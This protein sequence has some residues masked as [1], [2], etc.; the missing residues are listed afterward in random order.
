MA[1]AVSECCT[2]WAGST[3]FPLLLLAAVG[4]Y[5]VD[6]GQGSSP[7]PCSPY[8]MWCVALACFVIALIFAL[9]APLSFAPLKFMYAGIY[10]AFWF[11]LKV[12]AYIYLFMWLR[13]TLPRFRFDQLMRLGW[14][15]LIP[16]ALVNVAGV[17]VGLT[18]HSELGWNRWLAMAPTT[19]GTIG[20]ALLLIRWNDK[21]SAAA[22][23][24]LLGEQ[25]KAEDS[26]AG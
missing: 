17:G 14:H 23:A 4:G 13:F 3:L 7:Y 24:A 12:S 26:Y 6:A 8:F 15:I 18:L 5:C 25:A 10:G 11:L 20:V 21:Y 1:A 2:G 19:L 22:S 16:L 9:A